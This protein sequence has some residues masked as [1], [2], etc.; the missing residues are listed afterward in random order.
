VPE[1]DTDWDWEVV[2]HG[3]LERDTVVEEEAEEQRVG[4]C[5]V[6]TDTVEVVEVEGDNEA[7]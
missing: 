5:V 2:E 1:E 7:E 6:V 3:E 4:D